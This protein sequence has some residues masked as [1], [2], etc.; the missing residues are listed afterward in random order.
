M[1]PVGSGEESAIEFRALQHSHSF[2]HANFIATTPLMHNHLFD[3]RIAS[4]IWFA[5]PMHLS[6]CRLSLF[7]SPHTTLGDPEGAHHSKCHAQQIPPF[8]SRALSFLPNKTL[9]SSMSINQH[10]TAPSPLAPPLPN[11]L[12]R[13]RGSCSYRS[14]FSL[15]KHPRIQHQH[16]PLSLQPTVSPPAFPNPLP[17]HD[18]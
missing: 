1:A 16:N 14:D 15:T 12:P 18:H 11:P 13:G 3:A 9:F 10:A 17:H 6:A 2:S 8:F 4:S 7:P 5:S